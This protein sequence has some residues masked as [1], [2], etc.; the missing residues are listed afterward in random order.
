MEELDKIISD[1]YGIWAYKDSYINKTPFKPE[2]RD[3]YGEITKVGGDCIVNHFKEHF[4]EDTIFYDLGCGTGKLV[5]HIGLQYNVKKSCGIELSKERMTC[6]K[7]IKEKYCKDKSNI[8]YIEGDMFENDLSD[9]T[10]IYIDNLVMSIP[11]INKLVN[12]LPKGCLIICRRKP[13]VF[14]F[15]GVDDDKFVTTYHNT[16]I[17][18]LIKE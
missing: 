8:S 14:E 12:I 5:A 4:N 16:K 10:V 17:F 3:V 9:A 1:I 18:H 13:T 6:A 11:I 7:L 2:Y 15:K